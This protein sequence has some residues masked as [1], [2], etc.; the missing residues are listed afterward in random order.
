MHSNALEERYRDLIFDL[1]VSVIS[2][3][4]SAQRVT[5]AVLRLVRKKTQR[6]PLPFE[7]HE[8]AWVLQ[9]TCEEILAACRKTGPSAQDRAEWQK[10]EKELS[11]SHRT[12]NF[13]TFFKRLR[14]EERLLLILRDKYGFT[15]AE[16]ATILGTPEGT[17]KL[18]RQQAF[19]TLESWIWGLG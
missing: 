11:I 15:F 2:D 16:I 6:A 14:P 18:L 19:S 13:P 4:E 9:R 7:L 8:R 12:K 5:L 10:L 1:A 3:R 17:L